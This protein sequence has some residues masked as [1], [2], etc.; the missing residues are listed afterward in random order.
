[1][2][3]KQYVSIVGCTVV[4]LAILYLPGVWDDKTSPE[5]LLLLT[6]ALVFA[7]TK[8]GWDRFVKR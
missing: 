4:I 3:R 1:M 6:V 5:Q 7:L 8:L 2:N